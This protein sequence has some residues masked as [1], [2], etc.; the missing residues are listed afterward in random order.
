MATKEKR[1]SVAF[2]AEDWKE[3]DRL[4]RKHYDK[5]YSQIVKMIALKG[6]E[7]MKAEEAAKKAAI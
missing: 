3:L 7:A 2:T 4:K 5:P 6:L 1:I